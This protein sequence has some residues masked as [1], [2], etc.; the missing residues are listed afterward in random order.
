MSRRRFVDAA[1]AASSGERTS[2]PW[3]G[4]AFAQIQ[5]ARPLYLGVRAD[6]T[7]TIRDD[8]LRRRAVG[9]YLTWYPSE[10]LRFRAGYEHLWSDI[11]DEDGRRS[12]VPCR[13]QADEDGRHSA[14][15]QIDFV[16]GAHPPE[17]FWVNK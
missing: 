4:F 7:R 9:G 15:A 13:R 8:R 11:A 3:G 6:D 10:F 17:P 1:D 5:L 14:F 16:M 12:D 2:K